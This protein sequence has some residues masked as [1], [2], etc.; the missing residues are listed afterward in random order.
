MVSRSP[1]I[2]DC[3]GG[4]Q[5][6]HVTS[7][8]GEPL[9]VTPRSRISPTSTHPTCMVTAPL[10]TA[11]APMCDRRSCRSRTRSVGWKT[12]IPTGTPASS[13]WV[14]C[15]VIS[16][17]TYGRPKAGAG[18]PRSSVISSRSTKWVS[19]LSK[20]P[21]CPALTTSIILSK[22]KTCGMTPTLTF[23]KHK[24]KASAR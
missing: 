23:R 12:G 1:S 10:R 16:N 11:Q 8:N 20:F 3:A 15:S 13:R 24:G 21:G 6:A 19:P 9:R 17:W 2:V 4:R 5:R 18:L 14:P 7:G 22:S